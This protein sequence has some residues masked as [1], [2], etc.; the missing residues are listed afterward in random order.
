[1]MDL[2]HLSGVVRMCSPITHTSTQQSK[3]QSS[4][5]Y[6]QRQ[7]NRLVFQILIH[8]SYLCLNMNEFKQRY[9]LVLVGIWKSV[10][11]VLWTANHAN[12]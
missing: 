2:T 7:V 5:Q 11:H 8:V 12:P 9:R 1:M 3:E 10:N 4:C 6:N